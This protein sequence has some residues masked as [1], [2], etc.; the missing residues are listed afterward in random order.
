MQADIEPGFFVEKTKRYLKWRYRLA[1]LAILVLLFVVLRRPILVQ[2]G[3][4][5][6]MS[7]ITPLPCDMIVVKGGNT[8]RKAKISEAIRLLQQGFGQR[9]L[10]VLHSTGPEYDTFGLTN[11]STLICTAL[12]SLGIEPDHYELIQPKL[13]PPFTL[14]EAKAVA[15]YL[16]GKDVRSVLLLVDG[17]QMRRTFMVYRNA[18]QGIGIKVHPYTLRSN[19]NAENWWQFADGFRNV[20]GEYLKLM[21]YY[22][23]GYLRV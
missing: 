20:V 8:I 5:L 6:E 14:N 4:Y 18:M 19:C 10:L 13:T 2:V 23:R 9:I 3:Q 22:I 15:A 21:Y 7:T 17:F 12:D 16:D 1:L 11:Y